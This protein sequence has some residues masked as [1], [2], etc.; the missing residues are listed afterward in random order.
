MKQHAGN[1]KVKVILMQIFII[2]FGFVM[3]Y[4]V[5]WMISSAFKENRDIFTDIGL[6]PTVF[7]LN[8]FIDG[9]K[10]VGNANFGVF[11]LNSF[12]IVIPVVVLTLV[13]RNDRCLRLCALP[14]S[15]KEDHVFHHDR[16]PDASHLRADDPYLCDV[17]QGGLGQY[18]SAFY[19][20]GGI[21]HQRLFVYMLVQ[22][23]RG[24]PKELDEAAKIDGCNS[25]QI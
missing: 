2:V 5:L 9:W 12:K 17:L 22:F 25:F 15:G 18:L 3:V 4:P 7:N 24:I 13:S 14:V 11:F 6:M 8:A 20:S 1:R 21:F 10:G 19:R 16:Y 23:V